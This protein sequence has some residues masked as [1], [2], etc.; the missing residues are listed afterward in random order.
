MRSSACRPRIRSLRAKQLRAGKERIRN[1]STRR[2][3]P[4]ATV[5]LRSGLNRRIRDE[6][7]DSNCQQVVYLDSRT[8]QVL[9]VRLEM[10][11]WRIS[12][13]YLST[14]RDNALIQL[15]IKLQVFV[16][17]GANKPY[18]GL[19]GDQRVPDAGHGLPNAQVGV[20]LVAIQTRHELGQERRQL[21]ASLSC[22]HVEAKSCTLKVEVRWEDV[23]HT[24][25]SAGP[26]MTPDARAA[27][28]PGV[29]HGVMIGQVHE[30]INEV[31]LV[32][33]TGQRAE[34]FVRGQAV[35]PVAAVQRRGGQRDQQILQ[36]RNRLRPVK[37]LDIIWYSPVWGFPQTFSL[38]HLRVLRQRM[39]HSVHR[40]KHQRKEPAG[41]GRDNNWLLVTT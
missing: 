19:I 5:P 18:Q 26:G 22:N 29:P 4:A 40:H 33:V 2:A 23:R 12:F 30:L 31:W 38:K 13:R 16:L 39:F 35:A 15:L 11:S 7:D 37:L 9:L 8:L 6:R 20:K 21:L 3:C 41:K 28:L 17:A 24:G 27:Y 10:T 34:F 14:C 36:L 1:T 32:Q 25:G